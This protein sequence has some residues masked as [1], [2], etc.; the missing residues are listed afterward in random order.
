MS[1]GIIF[2]ILIVISII[3]CS[4]FGFDDVE[5]VFLIAVVGAVV[6]F[7]IC[8]AAMCIKEKIKDKLDHAVKAKDEYKKAEEKRINNLEKEIQKIEEKQES[9]MSLYDKAISKDFRGIGN[10]K[11]RLLFIEQESSSG[12]M[13]E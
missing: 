5:L 7:F 6:L 9:V 12:E 8:V 13:N 11:N 3:I 4:I 2:A 10:L 1:L